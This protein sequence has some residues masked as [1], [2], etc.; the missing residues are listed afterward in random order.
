VWLV[1]RLGRRRWLLLLSERG[2]VEGDG[3]SRALVAG[4]D[5]VK[6]ARATSKQT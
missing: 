3:T 1:G 6:M 4:L 5:C 2:L